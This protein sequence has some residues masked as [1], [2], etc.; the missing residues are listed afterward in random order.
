MLESWEAVVDC[1]TGLD[2]GERWAGRM[3]V[4]QGLNGYGGSTAPIFCPD[5]FSVHSP[6]H[7]G[8]Q[9]RCGS[10]LGIPQT[11]HDPRHEAVKDWGLVVS[12]LFS[13]PEAWPGRRTDLTLVPS[14]PSG[15][16]FFSDRVGQS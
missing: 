5:V 14:E 10:C 6:P 2:N 11:C 8:L 3:A 16:N 1:V 4:K 12:S 9:T 7:F 13:T 15:N